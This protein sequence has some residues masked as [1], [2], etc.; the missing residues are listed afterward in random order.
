MGEDFQRRQR[1]HVGAALKKTDI[2]I[3]TAK[4]A[5]PL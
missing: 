5:L 3:S 1:E 4:P 2:V